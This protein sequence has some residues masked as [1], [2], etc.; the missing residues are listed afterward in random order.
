MKKACLTRQTL[1]MFPQMKF[2]TENSLEA[3]S[4]VASGSSPETVGFEM[5]GRGAFTKAYAS[6]KYVVK[7]EM[8]GEGDRENS[9]AW[10]YRKW[11]LN[12]YK[13][14]HTSKLFKKVCKNILAPTVVLYDCV[15]IQEKVK[16]IGNSFSLDLCFK[17][18]DLAHM[19]GITD[20]HGA[21]WGVTEAGE[22]KIFDI[23]PNRKF[24]KGR[25]FTEDAQ[26]EKL[27]NEVK[28]L[29]QVEL[30][31]KLAKQRKRA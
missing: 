18:E 30:A 6:D 20:M 4:A 15:V 19:I 3:A 1:L 9:A 24:P 16:W 5:L 21:N 10:N 28:N 22:V 27:W 17:V 11:F 13:A 2:L 8:L 31:H 12:T 7:G 14:R 26:L 25:A 23:M 29:V